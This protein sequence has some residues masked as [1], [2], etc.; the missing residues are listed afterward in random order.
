MFVFFEDS[1]RTVENKHGFIS[2]GSLW[3]PQKDFLVIE[4]KFLEL[5]IDNDCWAEFSYKNIDRLH[6]E[7]YKK[8]LNIF[9]SS[10]AK[11]NFISQIKPTAS[12]LKEYHKGDMESVKMKMM[13]NLVF[14]NYKRYKNN[15]C[16][17][18]KLYL[19]ADEPFLERGVHKD[20]FLKSLSTPTKIPI[21]NAVK[22]KSHSLNCLQLTDLLTGLTLAFT[23]RY[24]FKNKSPI[25]KK[26]IPLLKEIKDLDSLIPKTGGYPNS[27]AKIN[28]WYHRPGI[29]WRSLE[30]FKK[31]FEKA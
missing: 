26:A 28:N 31:P 17:D 10:D 1:Y 7:T 14:Y 30:Y 18:K 6:I 20:E 8:L 22:C 29:T 13:F 4:K 15:I 11:F 19:I 21:R 12:E 3:I 5:R 24:Y 2:L 27:G 16:T 25:K 9:A 23:T